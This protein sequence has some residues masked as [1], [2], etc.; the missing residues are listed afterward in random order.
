MNK[1]NLLPQQLS[2]SSARTKIAPDALTT[3]AKT[4]LANEL[5]VVLLA[6]D[7]MA[8]G[9]TLA[10]DDYCRLHTAHQHV[11]AVL[12]NLTGRSLTQ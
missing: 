1:S 6:A 4:A 9:H 2:S 7:R 5:A 3:A 8:A 11:L 10:W 12:A